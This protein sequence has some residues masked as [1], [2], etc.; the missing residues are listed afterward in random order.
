M[1]LFILRAMGHDDNLPEYQGFFSDVPPGQWYTGYVEHLREHSITSGL[2]GGTYGPENEATRAQI[3][4]AIVRALGQTPVNP[5][6]TVFSDVSA[7]HWAAGYI[8]LLA[9]LGITTGYLDGTFRPNKAASRTEMIALVT[10]AWD[11]SWPP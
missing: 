9:Q 3:A 5:T 10:R 2:A 8:E 11:L 4:V 7:V 6:G 1:A